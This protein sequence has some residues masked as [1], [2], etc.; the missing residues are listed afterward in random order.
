MHVKYRVEGML[1]GGVNRREAQQ[2]ILLRI[3]NINK[4]ITDR[5]ADYYFQG[6]NEHDQH[7]WMASIKYALSNPS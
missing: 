7:Q 1:E 3:I 4:S 6:Q 2:T 5:E